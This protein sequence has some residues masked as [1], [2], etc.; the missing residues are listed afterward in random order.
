MPRRGWPFRVRCMAAVTDSRQLS[1]LQD[2]RLALRNL[3]SRPGFTIVAVLT[4][5]IGVGVNTVA[6][7]VVN[8]L[9]IK[10]FGSQTGSG[11]GRNH[12]LPGGAEEGNASMPEYERFVDAM[13]GA[14]ELAAEGRSTAAWRHD[15]RTE[16][17]WVL[18]VSSNYFSLVNAALMAGA[19]RVPAGWQ[20]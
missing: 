13:A 10:G 1:I 3:R 7:G 5:A 8:G 20:R 12:T 18:Y 9:L 15:G 6:F 4:L 17:A 19:V 14:V 11:G 2:L 16:T